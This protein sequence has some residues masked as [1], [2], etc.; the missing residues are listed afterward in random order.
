[1][2]KDAEAL[3]VEEFDGVYEYHLLYEDIKQ[4]LRKHNISISKLKINADKFT[5]SIHCETFEWIHYA[6]AAK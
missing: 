3:G 5:L 4:I 2:I 1:V 6:F